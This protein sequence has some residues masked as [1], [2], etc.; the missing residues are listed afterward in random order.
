MAEAKKIV[1]IESNDE[2]ALV[3]HV[4]LVQG[5]TSGLSYILVCGNNGFNAAYGLDQAETV[6]NSLSKHS[7]FGDEGPALISHQMKVE[8]ERQLRNMEGRLAYVYKKGAVGSLEF[9][10]NPMKDCLNTD[11]PALVKVPDEVR[12]DAQF[13]SDLQLPVLKQVLSSDPN[14]FPYNNQDPD[15]VYSQNTDYYIDESPLGKRIDDTVEGLDSMKYEVSSRYFIDFYD[16][17]L[18]TTECEEY[19]QESDEIK[20]EVSA[21]TNI[22]N[23][24]LITLGDKLTEKLDLSNRSKSAQKEMA[25]DKPSKG[26]SIG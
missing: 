19:L 10:F 23:E 6:I 21:L 22:Y 9:E 15:I 3:N 13:F 16:E 24:G 25:Q 17:H 7:I 1:T 14:H 8:L 2:D 11:D 4:S 18:E 20:K 26:T 5:E 12:H